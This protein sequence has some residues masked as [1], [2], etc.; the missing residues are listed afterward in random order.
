M[1]IGNKILK[2]KFVILF[3]VF[4]LFVCLVFILFFFIPKLMESNF[5]IIR[6]KSV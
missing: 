1:D 6:K 5:L 2:V 4:C 3:F